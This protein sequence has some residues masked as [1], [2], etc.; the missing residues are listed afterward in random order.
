MTVHDPDVVAF[1]IRRPWPTASSLPSVNARWRVRWPFVSVL[2]RELYFPDLITI[3]HRE[4]GG[5][6]SGEVCKHYRRER[7]ADGTWATTWLRDWRWHVWHW[8][9]QVHPLQH[10]RRWALTRCEWCGGRSR[11][12]D[13]VNCSHSWSGGPGRWWRGETG[14]Y[15]EDC[16]TIMSAHK[17]SA[18]ES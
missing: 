17:R 11:K 5:A 15:H 7:Q 16:S 12:D 9:I 1:S 8:R 4:P 3:W 14:L 18:G 2:G 13:P 10:L 6:D